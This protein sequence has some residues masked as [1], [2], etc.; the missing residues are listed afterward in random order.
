MSR[1]VEDGASLSIIIFDILDFEALEKKLGTKPMERIILTMEKIINNALRRVADVAIKDTKAIM[2]L[3]PDTRKENAYIVTG[4]LSQLLEDYLVREQKTPK[5]E[6]RS[7]VVC[8]P[9]EA[10]TLE[11]ILDR[12]YES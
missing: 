1:C 10:K 11:E 2:V 6:I 8:F 5:V 9:E 12:I 4:R 3:L 7:S